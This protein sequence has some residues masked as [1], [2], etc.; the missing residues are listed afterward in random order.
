MN[1]PRDA[2]RD[3]RALAGLS[4][5]PGESDLPVGA[6]VAA[7]GRYRVQG[8]QMRAG[9]ELWAQRAGARLLLEDDESTPERAASLAAAGWSEAGTADRGD[10]RAPAPSGSRETAESCFTR[11]VTSP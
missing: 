7:S 11:S 8:M 5:P 10:G 9:L 3:P 6:P 2:G 1:P 4:R